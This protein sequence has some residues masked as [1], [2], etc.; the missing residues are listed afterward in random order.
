MYPYGV[1]TDA[2]CETLTDE[3]VKCAFTIKPGYVFPGDDPMTLH[4]QTIYGYTTFE[5]FLAML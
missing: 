1:Y 2:A 3:S 4:R 5:E